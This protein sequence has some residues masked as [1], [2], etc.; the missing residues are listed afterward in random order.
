MAKV[1][2]ITVVFNDG[3]GLRRTLES[4]LHQE[5]VA[6]EPIVIDG[7]SVDSTR[8]VIEHYSSGLAQWVSEPDEGIFH[9]MDKGLSLATGDWV[10][11]MNAGDCFASNSVLKELELDSAREYAV[12]YGSKE[13]GGDRIDPLPVG[14]A[15]YAGVIF[16]CHQ[17][18]LFNRRQLGASLHYHRECQIY[19]DFELVARLFK[20]GFRFLKK[21][22][23]VARFEGGGVSARVSRQK[24][25]E[26]YRI[27][28]MYFGW[29]GIILGFWNR[30]VRRW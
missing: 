8:D 10:I 26:K 22:M 11:F 14:P 5:S 28:W 12:V 25:L 1:S 2:V 20:E 17:A 13:Q 23:V 29:P 6:L 27:L 24:R 15:T 9:A 3:A 19:G 16:A 30:F 4:V 18:M 21:D 7:G